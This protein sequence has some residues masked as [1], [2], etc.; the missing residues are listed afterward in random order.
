MQKIEELIKSKK[1]K[2]II[3]FVGDGINDA[4][5]L[6]LSDVGISMGGIGSDSAI[7]ASDIV[8]MRDN[9]SSIIEGKKVA[10]K[11]VRI[12]KQNIIFALSVKFSVLILSALGI[13]NM[14]WAVFAD[15]GVSVIAILNAMRAI[16]AK[17]SQKQSLSS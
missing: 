3:A 5:A 7:E 11:T 17:F 2:D 12:V 16:R 13:T 6:M 8:L 1:K 4:P 15:V 14:W 10:R 9:L